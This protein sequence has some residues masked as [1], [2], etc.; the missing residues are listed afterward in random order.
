MT[1]RILFTL[2]AA[3]I[4]A[5]PA[6]VT[7]AAA[8]AGPPPLSLSVEEPAGV[9]WF[10]AIDGEAQGPFTQ[11]QILERGLAPET[12]VWR[13]GMA[14]WTALGE[15]EELRRPPTDVVVRP[16]PLPSEDDD[17][18][19]YFVAVDGASS[20]ALSR[21]E[22]ARRIAAGSIDGSTLIW[23]EGMTDWETLS[24][25]SL[26]SLLEEPDT[27]DT[28]VTPEELDGAD[29]IVGS[30]TGRVS[31]PVDGLPTPVEIEIT[32]V[33][34]RDGNFSYSGSGAMDL[35]GQGIPQPVR[36]DVAVEGTWRVVS[37]AS[38]RVRTRVSGTLEMAAPELDLTESE[39]LDET[40]VLEI[41]DRDT[42]RDE[43]GNVFARSPG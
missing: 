4:L 5:A 14:G 7:S 23:H 21:E 12:L 35:S 31:Q 6:S 24:G 18:I 8:Q 11:E 20:D 37:Q 26:A 19:E 2:A 43:D 41:V 25:S 27:P 3:L 16:P 33:Y 10:A 42:I 29:V 28:P 15:V 38:N 9:S 17:G 32:A 1:G 36:L 30:W 13:D 39:P 34:D 22:V 40:I